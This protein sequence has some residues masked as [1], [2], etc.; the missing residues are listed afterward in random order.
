MAIN[1]PNSPNVNDTHTEGGVTWKWDGTSWNIQDNASSYTLPIATAGSLG[2]IK[3]GSRLTINATTGVLDADVQGGGGGATTL[4]A[5]TD[6]DVTG[7]SNGKI[8]KY[9]GTSWEIADDLTGGGGSS[10]FT[11][12]ADTPSS[13]TAGQWL[14]VNTGG[15]ALEWTDAPSGSNT[16]YDLTAEAAAG[17]TAKVRLTGSDSTTDDVTFTASGG[18]SYSITGN[19]IQIGSSNSLGGLSDVTISASP[20]DNYVLT[21]DLSS[22][23]W[24]PQPVPSGSTPDLNAVLGAGNT[25]TTAATVGDLTCDNLT[26]NG[27]TTTV[28]SNTVNIGDSNLT[29]NSDETGTP[30]QDGG[31]TIERGT[32]DNVEIR[33][34]ETTD[35]WQF[36]ND[37]TNYSDIGSSGGEANVQVDWNQSNSAA[38]DFIKNKPTLFSGSYNDLSNK[39]TIPAAQIQSDWNQSN[40]SALDFIKNK[41]SITSDTNDY[42]NSASF[43]GSTITLGRTG[44]L[45]DLTVDIGNITN[46]V[47]PVGTIVMYNG[48]VAPAGW[49]LCDGVQRTVNGSPYTPPDLRDKFIVGAGNIYTRGDT[50]GDNTRTLGESNLP[51]HTHGAGNFG[52]NNTG[53]HTHDAGNFGSNNTGGHTHGG[54]NYAAGN[55]GSHT[56][57][58]GN[59][60]ADLAG[61]HTHQA[62]VSG[63]TGNQSNNHVHTMSTNVSTNNT[64][65]H[66]HNYNT[67]S[68]DNQ[69]DYTGPYVQGGTNQGSR[70]TSNTGGHAHNF[71]IT[72]DT[73]GISA[74][75]T[76]SGNTSPPLTTSEHNHGVSG[77]SGSAGSH[78]HSMSGNSGS[79]GDH[80]HN[81]SGNTGS[82]GDHSHNI[83]GNTGSVGSGS[84]FDL[85]PPYYA[86]T[87]IIKTL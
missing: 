11:G 28:N 61:S 24:E 22:S 75:H 15:T 39:P 84:S 63:T 43:S 35:K 46:G 86:I 71:N 60:S 40:S 30:S 69:S 2:G 55:A 4:G 58:D 45:A 62:N 76:H 20:T 42:V 27:T 1:F 77:N 32:S 64:G 18:I 85:R 5:L 6:V 59:Y 31:F 81:I 57:G 65:G 3:V 9:N 48:D 13:L 36:T 33:W 29:L 56:H 21:Y 19:T 23:T 25:S 68:W 66:S 67:A 87:F 54:G 53:G 50:G 74:N 80:S 82:A 16:T 78:S 79:A 10:N 14:K 72:A 38:D 7:A 17:N 8:I 52:S 49:V 73:L 44:S 37:G 34:N 41:P 12:L 26:V 83:S 51:S 70:S 47:V